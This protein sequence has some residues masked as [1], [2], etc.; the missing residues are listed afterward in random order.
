MD[1]GAGQAE[2]RERA[3]LLHDLGVTATDDGR[4]ALAARRLRRGL[5]LLG[6][7]P[8]T[9][10]QVN[11]Q[12]AAGRAADLDET[13]RAPD[14]DP[15]S[16]AADPD[17]AALLA[18]MLTSL[19][20]AEAEQGR[21]GLGMDLLDQAQRCAPPAE[22]PI[23]HAQRGLMCLRTG[24]AAEALREL[25]IAAPLLGRHDGVELARVLL[26]R[27][28]IHL[29]MGRVR[30]ARDDVR[31][32]ARL[33]T[34]H[35]HE[36]IAVKALHNDG[37]CDLLLGDIPTALARFG[38]VEQA[39]RRLVPGFLPVLALDQARALLAAGLADE[40]GR[41]LDEALDG[42][43]R[44][45]LIQDY[46]E[47]ELA[48]AQA[49][50][51]AGRFPEA[52]VWARRAESRFR[53]RR[54]QAW[55]LRAVLMRL[56]AEL[57]QTSSPG[58]L[59]RRADDLAGRLAGV[60]LAVESEMA[61][62]LSVRALIAAGHLARAAA[63]AESLGPPRRDAPLEVRLM[64]RLTETEL[65]RARGRRGEAL[66]QARAGL[67]L[68]HTHRGRLGSLDLRTGVTAL[69]FE[70]AVRGLGA[71]LA[72][73][74]AR[75][76]F[77]W[78][79]RCRAQAFRYPPIRPPE[80]EQT[81]DA[82]A[83]LRLLAQQMHADETAARRDPELRRRCLEL[84]HLIRERGWQLPGVGAGLPPAS[85]GMVQAELAATGLVLVSLL[86]VKGRV[87]ALL[88]GEGRCRLHEL[89]PYE[90]LAEAV[91]RLTGDLNALAG[92]RLRP[93]MAEV[94]G[95]SARRQLA[96]I[97]AELLTPLLPAIRG[98]SGVVVVPTM[99]L[100]AIPWGALPG[101]LGRPVIS[102]PSA[103]VWACAQWARKSEVATGEA[104]LLVAGPDLASADAEIE[105]IAAA[106]PKA[107]RLT[108][109]SAT[110]AATLAALDGASVAHL[111]AH[112]HHERENVLFSRLVLSDG[113]LMAYDIQRLR[114]APRHVVL[115][116][117][118]V[119]QAVVRPGDELLG[120]TSALL[121]LGTPTVVSS[122]TRVP[123]DLATRV[124]T[125]YHRHLVLG[126]EPAAA[127][128]AASAREPLSTFVCFGAG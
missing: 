121:H 86:N 14:P 73:G 40:A 17:S 32:S 11:D 46:G 106:Y 99:A 19:A 56:R 15:A 3:K 93:R 51:N 120:F 68:I 79:E 119:G 96:A 102:A 57:P 6:W 128:A 109:G 76:V 103:L 126:L 64:R 66:R 7:Q 21:T 108:G 124:M 60:G 42:F 18:R 8:D 77:D 83:E 39:Y 61:R 111:A 30:P 28:V 29:M 113:P 84:E 59:A 4:P 101:L 89:G 95:A 69:G 88:L 92:R 67:A 127:L 41:T 70:L 43:R 50:L 115:S 114:R 53:R 98:A 35:G 81:A 22:L 24:R 105:Q 55:A 33:A 10:G 31:R 118:D 91:R 65:A 116:S 78:S 54:S 20:H 45:R 74:S 62:M 58:P 47:A 34:A 90:P 122:V 123:D 49:A 97:A 117:C 23:V 36:V 63:R 1:V 44:Q 37:Y 26:N 2:I 16:R 107:H 12:D 112:G 25:D 5:A 100:S 71:A 38:E 9:T 80:D 110:V 87:L 82:L 13:G 75:L 85:T 72:N 104:P 94:I 27:S 125:A 52:G 48:R